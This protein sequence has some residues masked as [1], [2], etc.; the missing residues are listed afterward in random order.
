MKM[1]AFTFSGAQ[2]PT[3]A[4]I[5]WLAGAGSIALTLCATALW[6]MSLQSVDI[7][8]INDLGLVSIL[9]ALAFLALLVVQVSF[10][11][12]LWRLSVPALLANLVALIFMLYGV[13]TLLGEEPRFAV[14]WV[15]V[16][17]TEYIMRTGATATGLDA[18]FSW[19]GFFVLSAL[20]TQIAGFQSAIAFAGW[21]TV[22]FNLLYLGPLLMIFAA[23]TE[24]RRLVWLGVWLFYLTNWIGQDY[25]A[26]QA[27]S[28]CMYLAVLA[29]L[30]K[31]FKAT[32]APPDR[33]DARWQRLGILTR[34][35]NYLYGWLTAPDT[36]NAASRPGQRAGLLLVVVLLFALVVSSH[37]LTPF[38]TLAAVAALVILRRCSLRGLPLL[39]GVMIATWMSYMTVDFLAGHMGWLIGGVGQVR[40]SVGRN[41]TDRLAGSPEHQFVIV[42]RL[43]MSLG[44]WGLAF[45]G[46]VRRTSNGRRDTT[47]ALLALVPFAFLGLQSYGGEV[48]LRV[49]IFNLPFMAFFA[50]ALF[51]TT[52]TSGTTWRT[53][54]ALNVVSVALVGGFLFTRHGNERMDYMTYKEVAGVRYLYQIAE[55]G[56]KF[57]TASPNIPWKFQDV[58]KYTYSPERD[59]FALSDVGAIVELMDDPRYPA[60]YLILTRSQKAHGELFY[61]LPQGWGERLDQKLRESGKFRL[62]FDNGDA[63][64]FVLAQRRHGASR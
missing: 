15:H 53:L 10:S 11:M 62:L 41:V 50:A 7:R 56:A 60:T 4:K 8:G 40:D 31:W 44:L 32:T 59:E 19:P 17:F 22:F 27:L 20:A 6:V 45:L 30:L 64:I 9:P 35:A 39:M 5:S 13:T 43:V 38:A 24:D 37:Q 2:A 25:F 1:K 21:A 48:L 61:G 12:A 57:V 55:P 46:G 33:A 51:F 54:L 3:A 16:G 23:L 47:C 26:P 36:P 29:V 49:Y 58:E 63:E 34:P 52:A 42:M 28:Y 14:T 18:R